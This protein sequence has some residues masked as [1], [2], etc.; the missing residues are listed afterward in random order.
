MLVSEIVMSLFLFHVQTLNCFGPRGLTLK[1]LFYGL[2]LQIFSL[3]GSF[4]WFVLIFNCSC[5][6]LL[7]YNSFSRYF[8]E[9]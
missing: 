7:S 9:F 8:S 3:Q 6:F 1:L 4:Q 5:N 2:I